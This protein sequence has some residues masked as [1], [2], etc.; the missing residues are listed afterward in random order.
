MR[1]QGAAAADSDDDYSDNESSKKKNRIRMQPISIEGDLSVYSIIKSLGLYRHLRRT[2][3]GIHAMSTKEAAQTVRRCSSC[4]A[5][6]ITNDKC[7][8]ATISKS[9]VIGVMCALLQPDGHGLIYRYIEYLGR[10]GYTPSTLLHN[11]EYTRHML[12][13]AYRN[14]P[15]CHRKNCNLSSLLTYLSELCSQVRI[16]RHILHTCY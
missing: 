16:N 2:F 9:M 15:E 5:Y 7:Y 10:K 13:F 14:I 4:I 11:V 3:V 6:C 12:T 1:Q 8:N